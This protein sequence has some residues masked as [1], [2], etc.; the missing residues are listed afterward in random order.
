MPSK[1]QLDENLWFLYICL[2]KSDLKAID[3]NAVGL[4]TSLK[5]PAARMRYTR[6]K[7]QIE[8]GALKTTHGPRTASSFSSPPP[9]AASLSSSLAPVKNGTASHGQAVKRKRRTRAEMEED[10]VNVR[11]NRRPVGRNDGAKVERNMK[12]AIPSPSVSTRLEGMNFDTK[13]RTISMKA[14]I[15]PRN[16]NENERKIKIENLSAYGTGFDTESE[17]DSV[18]DSEEELPLAKLCKR[19]DLGLDMDLG[20]RQASSPM[21]S[22]DVVSDGLKHESVEANSILE[23]FPVHSTYASQRNG[24]LGDNSLGETGEGNENG[25]GNRSELPIGMQYPRY[26][27]LGF[28][29]HAIGRG[30]GTGKI[31]GQGF[32]RFRDQS[33]G[34]F[35]RSQIGRGRYVS[36][37]AGWVN[38]RDFEDQMSSSSPGPRLE[39]YARSQGQLQHEEQ[40]REQR[41]RQDQEKQQRHVMESNGSFGVGNEGPRKPL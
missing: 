23:N 2:Q 15:E 37:Y 35:C 24:F 16:E 3:F 26:V 21:N 12:Q 1:I 27:P 7:K 36:P 28:T 25:D 29:T 18:E 41:E 6:L 11:M 38:G 14:K 34:V 4:A 33:K 30:N 20:S 9:A 10:S 19:R 8:S 17:G 32:A 5:P 31:D 39:M 13:I 22:D 40:F